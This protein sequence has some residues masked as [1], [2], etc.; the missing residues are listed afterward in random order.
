MGKVNI[1]LPDGLLDEVDSRAK[2]AGT[3]RSGFLQEAASHYLTALD[4]RASSQA[5]S[6]RRGTA[7][8]RMRSLADSVGAPGAA[9]SIRELRDAAPRWDDR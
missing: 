1:S 8:E 6:R 4:E 3:T 7:L 9:R 5:R 2:A